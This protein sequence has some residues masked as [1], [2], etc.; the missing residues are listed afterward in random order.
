MAFNT[1]MQGGELV[2][3]SQVRNSHCML[4]NSQLETW[5][6]VPGYEIV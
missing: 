6:V 1:L 5:C 4:I 3:H 2:L